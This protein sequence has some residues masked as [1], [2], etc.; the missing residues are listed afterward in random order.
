MVRHLILP[1]LLLLGAVPASAQ[2]ARVLVALNTD[3]VP[4]AFGS[5][6]ET[7]LTL[8]NNSSTPLVVEGA[9]P[10]TCPFPDCAPGPIDPHSSIIPTV[11]CAAGPRVLYVEASRLPDLAATLRTHDVSKD[12]ETWGTVVP[13][14]SEESFRSKTF[15]LVD[16]PLVA[17]FRSTLR[18]YDVDPTTAGDVIVRAYRINASNGS[19]AR[20]ELL[21]TITPVFTASSGNRFCGGVAELHLG[22]YPELVAAGRTRLEIVP[23]DEHKD[24]WAMVSVTQ[25]ATQF[26]TLITPA[27]P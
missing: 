27:A 12:A 8:A 15:S 7:K 13:V 14:V 23:S 2:Q 25:N 22:D 21:R 19:N 17:G 18:I 11:R 3:V 26:V 24:Y 4:G 5:L 20:D 10:D 6:W 9:G 16:V 1:L